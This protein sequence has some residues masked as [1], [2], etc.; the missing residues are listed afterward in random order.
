MKIA[1]YAEPIAWNRTGAN[2][3]RGML[4]R[5]LRIRSRD[6]FVFVVRKGSDASPV[7][8]EFLESLEESNWGVHV[9]GVP[10]KL[11]NLRGL[12][13]DPEYCRLGMC[14]DFYINMDLDPL[15]REEE[16]L[17]ATV[18]DVSFVRDPKGSTVPWHGVRIRRH[19]LNVL[20]KRRG[21]HA[22]TVSAF[23]EK[24][25]VDFRPGM[26]GRTHVVH[27]G[28][29]P[30]WFE[31][32]VAEARGRIVPDDPY[33]IWC[34]Y[35]SR[36]KNVEGLVRAY[37]MLASKT[38]RRNALP[39]LLI[40]GTV[41]RDSRGLPRLVADL[42]LGGRVRFLPFQPIEN[43]VAL[44]R[45]SIGLVFPSFY[46]G[47][48]VPVIE[49]MALGKPVLVSNRTALPEISGGLAAVCDPTDAAGI[50][51]GMAEILENPE[52]R[53]SAEERREWA[54]RFTHE[55]AADAYSRILD[56]LTV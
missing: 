22:V 55:A 24:D 33:W 56:S 45:H 25:L 11:V 46:E 8:R 27:N 48:G 21:T 38:P 50:A 16:P 30:I 34:G 42:G 9:T 28:I 37:S 14:A 5:L 43:L 6:D 47:F 49:A 53:S 12:L 20:E 36:R 29:D 19:A 26:K 35:V 13:G 3:G 54:G 1:V 4:R 23:T 31:E 44:V 40:V 18:A 7:F 17:L 51:K 15:G 10:R 2:P 32:T 52:G 41:G 39:A